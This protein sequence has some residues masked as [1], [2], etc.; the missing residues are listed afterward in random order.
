MTYE[1]EFGATILA[2]MEANGFRAT[3]LGGN[4]EGWVKDLP[5]GDCI[6]IAA[7][8]GQ[9]YAEPD[10]ACWFATVTKASECEPEAEATDMMLDAAMAWAAA[11]LALPRLQ[12]NDLAAVRAWFRA[13]CDVEMDWNPDDSADQVVMTATSHP[14]FSPA[15]AKL[16]QA[17]MDRAWEI[18]EAAKGDDIHLI[19]MQESNASRKARGLEPIFDLDDNGQLKD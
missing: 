1:Q 3:G 10:E 19:M 9:L 13:L 14:L 8:D 15:V 7:Y 12:G 6:T 17:D 18:V 4:L 5:N 2:K 11:I 16:A